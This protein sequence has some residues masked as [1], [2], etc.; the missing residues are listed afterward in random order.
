MSF[1]IEL[2]SFGNL[3]LLDQDGATHHH[4]RAVR[5][6]P[7]TD[8]QGGVSLMD[9]DGK[10]LAWVDDVNALPEHSRHLILEQLSLTEFMPEILKIERVS[11]YATPSIWSLVTSRG[12]T[13]LKLKGEEDIRRITKD[14][15]L[16]T[17]AN[18]I[19]FLIR[20]LHALD[21]PSRKI[22]DRFL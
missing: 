1:S 9:E 13:K 11:T 14:T 3:T 7:I 22:L 19:Q 10:E 21:K 8:P 20:D 18:G 16:I 4:V 17:D 2:D 6:F 5:A 15:L 12:K